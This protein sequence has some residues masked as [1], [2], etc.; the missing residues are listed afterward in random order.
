M[1]KGKKGAPEVAPAA[2]VSAEQRL[3]NFEAAL[4]VLGAATH[5]GHQVDSILARDKDPE[6][7]QTE[8]EE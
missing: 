5:T 8:D 2:E 1:A 4:R 6:Q 3:N 7:E